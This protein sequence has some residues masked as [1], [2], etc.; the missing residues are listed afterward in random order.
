MSNSNNFQSYKTNP[1]TNN[2]EIKETI[3]LKLLEKDPQLVPLRDI[4]LI[5]SCKFQQDFFEVILKLKN[6]HVYPKH[7][8]P[9]IIPLIQL[10]INFKIQKL[11]QYLFQNVIGIEEGSQFII[12]CLIILT[13]FKIFEL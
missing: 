12:R 3:S 8:H 13:N 6:I 10:A 7:K 1:K 2:T 4:V 9:E 11:Q 5:Y